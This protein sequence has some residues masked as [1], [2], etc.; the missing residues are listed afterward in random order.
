MLQ[1]CN[2]ILQQ[3]RAGAEFL[4]MP[5]GPNAPRIFL[6]FFFL[7]LSLY[8]WCCK[9][10]PCA[11]YLTQWLLTTT[12][13]VYYILFCTWYQIKFCFPNNQS[14]NIFLKQVPE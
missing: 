1:S 5:L 11:A 9:D 6:H 12:A 2:C 14:V 13:D 10:Q 4:L 8:I 7:F 3:C